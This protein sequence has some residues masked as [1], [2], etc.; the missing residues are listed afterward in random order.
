MKNQKAFSLILYLAILALVFSWVM[1]FLDPVAGGLSDSEVLEL[2]E[3]EQVRSFTVRDQRITLQL[4]QPYNGDTTVSA[5]LA[6]PDGFRQQMWETL[7]EQTE[8]GVLQS[9]R[10]VPE[11]KVKAKLEAMLIR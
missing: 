1:G 5:S 3:K 2:F 10:F 6:D 4:H 9:Y 11:E 7:R 8:S